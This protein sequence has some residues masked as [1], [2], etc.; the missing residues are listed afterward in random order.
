MTANG[1]IMMSSDKSQPAWMTFLT[2]FLDV[3][4][5]LAT[6]IGIIIQVVKFS[7]FFKNKS[8]LMSEKKK[9]QL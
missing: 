3:V 2:T 1:D 5:F 6:S 7:A 9:N 8:G 4:V